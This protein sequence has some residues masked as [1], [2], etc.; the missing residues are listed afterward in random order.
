[1][2]LYDN[3]DDKA[4]FQVYSGFALDQRRWRKK[5]KQMSNFQLSGLVTGIDT[6]TLIS[7]LMTIEQRTLK[8]YQ[9]R[10][11]LWEEKKQALAVAIDEALKNFES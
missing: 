9:Q 7:Q 3:K 1:M 2:F 11:V 10:K 4:F 6:E 8:I 5:G